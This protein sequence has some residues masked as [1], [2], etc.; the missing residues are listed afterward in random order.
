MK[1]LA[2]T[3]LLDVDPDQQADPADE[4]QGD[5]GIQDED[6]SGKPLEAPDEYQ[7]QCNGPCA[8]HG[9]RDDVDEIGDARVAPHAAIQADPREDRDLEQDDPWQGLQEQL[10]LLRRDIALEADEVGQ[11][12]SGADQDASM[13]MMIQKLMFRSRCFMGPD[14]FR[15][16]DQQAAAERSSILSA[17]AEGERL[18]STTVRAPSLMVRSP[19]DKVK[20]TDL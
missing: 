4:H 13:P 16:D 7:G 1:K 3:V 11:H 17:T 5:Q 10:H 12:G 15:P 2:G 19:V 20:V 8:D 9:R 14:F 18:E 6:A